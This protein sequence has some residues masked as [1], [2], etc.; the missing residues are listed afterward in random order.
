MRQKL[1]PVVLLALGLLLTALP[2]LAHHSVL[3]EYDS[4]NPVTL[5]VTRILAGPDASLPPDVPCID[6][7]KPYLDDSS[8]VAPL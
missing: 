2:A 6:S 1:P 8:R 7:D 5:D 3:A 4:K